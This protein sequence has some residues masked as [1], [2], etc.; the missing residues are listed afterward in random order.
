MTVSTIPFDGSLNRAHAALQVSG[1]DWIL[2][3]GDSSDTSRAGLHRLAPQDFRRVPG[4]F[5]RTLLTRC[6]FH[7]HG[8][9]NPQ[10]PAG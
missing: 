10:E 9:P 8:R 1:T 6:P 4:S 3:V 2:V 7:V 5:N